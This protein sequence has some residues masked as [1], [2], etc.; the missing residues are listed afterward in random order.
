MSKNF[1]SIDLKLTGAYAAAFLIFMSS[2]RLMLEN[3][4][5]GIPILN[6]LSFSN[7]IAYVLDVF[8]GLTYLIIFIFF[9]LMIRKPFLTWLFKTYFKH[10]FLVITIVIIVGLS[11]ASY[12]AWQYYTATLD[13]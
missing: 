4:Q 12:V 5:L 11:L 2:A 7:L 1:E 6:Y 3:G 9:L 8:Y 10:E 13:N